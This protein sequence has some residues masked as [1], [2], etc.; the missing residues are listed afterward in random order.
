[1]AREAI[2]LGLTT[3]AFGAEFFANG[4]ASSMVASHPGVL[5]EQAHARLKQEIVA[6]TTGGKRHSVLLLEEGIKV[7][8]LTIPPEDAQ[9]L[10]TRQ[11]QTLEIARWF[12]LPPHKLGDLQRATFSNI[13]QMATEFLQDTL[14]PWL[15]VWEQELARKLIRPLEMKQQ[16]IRHNVD[17]M[18]RGDY[19]TRMQGYAIA[20]QWGLMSADEVRALEE[21]NPLPQDQGTIYLTPANMVPADRIHEIVDSQVAPEPTAATPPVA[22]NPPNAPIPAAP[23]I[24]APTSFGRAVTP[25][26]IAAHRAVLVEALQRLVRKEAQ[27]ARRASKRGLAKFA[28]WAEAF[29]AKHEGDI[30]AVMRAGLQAHL[31][32]IGSSKPVDAAAAELA[33]TYV[34]GSRAE[35]PTEPNEL[36][37]AVDLLARRWESTRAAQLADGLMTEE[38]RHA[39]AD[40]Q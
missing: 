25:E 36:E 27:A 16:L 21:M 8:K 33:R 11:F 38:V 14:R 26:L 3:E 18:L 10:A 34:A 4:A 13:E 32:Q 37:N 39:L 15:V 20:R 9:F 22:V 6:N 24:T 2:G 17:G 23:A 19:V 29:Y 5:S 7:D 35:L 40:A 30:A 12:N 28:E 1:M 31:S